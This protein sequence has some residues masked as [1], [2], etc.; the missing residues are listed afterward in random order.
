MIDYKQIIIVLTIIVIL[1][2]LFKKSSIEGF[3][4]ETNTWGQWSY[5]SNIVPSVVRDYR[6]YLL[7][8]NNML[9]NK[10]AYSDQEHKDTIL[11]DDSKT[12]I[13]PQ[14]L[15]QKTIQH[16]TT[17]H[18]WLHI[19]VCVGIILFLLYIFTKKE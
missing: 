15:Y 16:I 5:N 3:D 1:W 7:R 10:I 8:D 2:L 13:V 9:K 18:K 6:Y 11:L 19:L 17:K 12:I 4:T 14:T